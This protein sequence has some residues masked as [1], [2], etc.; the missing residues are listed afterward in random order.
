MGGV[1]VDCVVVVEIVV[2]VDISGAGVVWHGHMLHGLHGNH[3]KHGGQT[4]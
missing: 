2:G 1:V 3:G 4:G